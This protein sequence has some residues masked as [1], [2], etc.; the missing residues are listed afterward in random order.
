MNIFFLILLISVTPQKFPLFCELVF[1]SPLPD[2]Q[3]TVDPH[4][5]LLQLAKIRFAFCRI[6]LTGSENILKNPSAHFNV[7]TSRTYYAQADIVMSTY[8]VRK[9]IHPDTSQRSL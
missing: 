1:F 4:L 8:D 2:H 5:N 3:R 6:L 9:K 7:L